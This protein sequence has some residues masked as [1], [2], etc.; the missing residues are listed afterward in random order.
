MAH[1]SLLAAVV[2]AGLLGPA[3]AHAASPI[4]LGD[5]QRPGIT[6]N[7]DTAYVTWLGNESLNRSLHFCRLPVGASSCQ[8]TTTIPVPSDSDTVDRAFTTFIIDAAFNVTGVAV[9]NHRYGA[10][11]PGFKAVYSFV[12]HNYGASFD[13]G[14]PV[15]TIPFNDAVK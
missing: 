10:D 2:T 15:G 3:V 12:S 4:V 5:G 11:V 6:V 7:G 8:V 9:L 14:T 13:R 1:R